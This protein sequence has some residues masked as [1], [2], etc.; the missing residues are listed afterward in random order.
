MLYDRSSGTAGRGGSGLR[1]TRPSGRLGTTYDLTPCGSSSSS[2]PFEVNLG[3]EPR[4]SAAFRSSAFALSTPVAPLTLL[5]IFHRPLAAFAASCLSRSSRS[6]S[7]LLALSRS[8]CSAFCFA[9]NCC[10]CIH[11]SCSQC[12]L[13]A[14]SPIS[15]CCW[16]NMDCASTSRWVCSGSA[17]RVPI[18]SAII[19]AMLGWVAL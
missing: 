9:W 10:Q 19:S 1:S 13:R 17:L 7:S 15:I 3:G 18:G 16:L 2:S 5:N 11:R 8:S 4:P 12:R 6:S 14:S